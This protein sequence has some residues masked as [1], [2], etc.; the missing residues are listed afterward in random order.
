LG[1]TALG[2]KGIGNFGEGNREFLNNHEA[3]LAIFLKSTPA[4]PPISTSII[5]KI[6]SKSKLFNELY[7]KL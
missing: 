6:V 1:S 4:P 2:R 3:L 5:V 7:V